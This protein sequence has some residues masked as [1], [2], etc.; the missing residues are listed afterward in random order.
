MGKG[1]LRGLKAAVTTIL[2]LSTGWWAAM[3]HI[4][5]VTSFATPGEYD[6]G[7]WWINNLTLLGIVSL[8]IPW[9]WFVSKDVATA[10]REKSAKP[11]LA[12]I[13]CASFIISNPF[14]YHPGWWILS[15][16]GAS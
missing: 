6:P 9:I 16:F 5:W 11:L 10:K 4:P 8:T 3:L 7:Y 15:V 14:M 12:H 1:E 13:P 2:S